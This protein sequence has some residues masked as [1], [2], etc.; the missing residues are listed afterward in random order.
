MTQAITI[1]KHSSP[2][3]IL[4]QHKWYV[5]IN[6]FF[7]FNGHGVDELTATRYFELLSRITKNAE[8]FDNEYIITATSTA[9]AYRGD[10]VVDE[11]TWLVE[12]GDD[13]SLKVSPLT[14]AQMI[15]NIIQMLG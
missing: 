4:V 10:L 15:N 13:S 2:E 9:E 14:A 1:T 7:L 3:A 8:D 11:A 5:F 6:G 12:I